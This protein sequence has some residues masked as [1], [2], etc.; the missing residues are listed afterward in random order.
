VLPHPGVFIVEGKSD[1]LT[2]A[3]VEPNIRIRVDP[4]EIIA[5][6]KKLQ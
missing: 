3:L 5:E 4:T 1:K 6:L 2:F